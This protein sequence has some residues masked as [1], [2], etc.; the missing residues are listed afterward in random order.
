MTSQAFS[1]FSRFA[2]ISALILL[3]APRARASSVTSRQ[4]ALDAHL[5]VAAELDVG[6]AAGHVGGDGD[7][8][9]HAGLGDDV[10][11]LLVVAGVQ[12]L[13]RDASPSSAAR[14]SSSDFSIETVPTSTGWPRSRRSADQLDDRLYFSRGACDRPRRRWSLRC[15]ATLVGISITSSL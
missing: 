7:G 4:L 5:E 11:F 10:G 1:T 8:A 2:A 3:D 6:A 15:T 13:V 14:T 12:H 9:G